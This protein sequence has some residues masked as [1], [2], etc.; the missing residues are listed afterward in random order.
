MAIDY[1]NPDYSS[2]FA[3]RAKRLI[4]IRKDPQLLEACHL[5][6]KTHP[7]DLVRDWGMTFEPRNLEKGLISAIPFIPFPRQVEFMQWLY[8]SWNGS[9]RGLVE[10]SRDF[11]ATWLAGAF[12]VSMWR[13]WPGFTAGFG[14]RKEDL[15]DKRGDPKTIFEKIR[16]FI[17]NLP[18]EFQPKGWDERENSSF[19]RIINPDNGST[20][21]GEAG[22]NIG[23][24][25]RM[26]IYIVD[27]AA[28]I[29]RQDATDAA[30]SQTTNCQIDISTPNGNGNAFYKK[31]NRT[32]SN[33]F[34]MD[35]KDD[36]RKDQAWYD[37]QVA[38]LD[39]VIVAQEIDRDYNASQENVFINSKWVE[40]AVD[41]H[42]KLGFEPIGMK[43]TSFDPA[44]VGD[45][46][47]LVYRHGN[48]ILKAEQKKKGDIRDAVPWAKEFVA[49]NK[50]DMFVYDADGMG[51]PII[52]LAIEDEF[53]A[54]NIPIT[55]FRG[56]GKKQDP[57][58]KNK[59]LDKTNDEAFKNRRA[60]FW[61]MARERFEETYNAVINGV[62]TDPSKLISISSEISEDDLMTLKAE[63]SRPQRK[64]AGDGR[65]KVES[66]EE[67]K[68]RG[69]SSPNLADAVIMSEEKSE[70]KGKWSSINYGKVSIA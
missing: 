62:Y 11:G 13:Y 26:S 31:R 23:R 29:P 25:A 7:W 48:V 39:E 34:V 46:K 38:G 42:I 63:L 14:S 66:K 50:T 58:T 5:H 3:E 57:G 49:A 44:D 27:E 65:I 43:R 6:Y 1:R 24:G 55:A 17:N 45:A 21:T 51:A 37:K 33:V 68:L 52:K 54:K 60:Q 20:I 53:E 2:I 12:C 9:E 40:A 47:A 19:L 56:N 18:I 16:F 22:D 61:Y 41:A 69:V 15:I 35:W 28:F 32:G 36:P 59:K 4:A 64:Y 67:M 70:I 10:K 8:T 30:L